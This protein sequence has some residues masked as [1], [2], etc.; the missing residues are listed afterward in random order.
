[1]MKWQESD[2]IQGFFKSFPYIVLQ[3]GFLE[4]K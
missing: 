2:S 1:M 3:K 4:E